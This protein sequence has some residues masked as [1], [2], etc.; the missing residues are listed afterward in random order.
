MML[1]FCT[2]S[3]CK[4]CKIGGTRHIRVS[5]VMNACH[6]SDSPSGVY[7]CN[8]DLTCEMSG[9]WL[10]LLKTAIARVEH[11]KVGKCEEWQHATS[12]L[13]RWWLCNRSWP[14]EGDEYIP[15]T[16]G[17]YSWSPRNVVAEDDDG[18]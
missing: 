1:I 7:A 3:T 13:T 11:S 6:L 12:L 17:R 10:C 18:R 2:H 5:D 14:V 9:W 15:T 8:A 4:G 16:D